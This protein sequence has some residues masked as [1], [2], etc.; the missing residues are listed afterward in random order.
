MTDAQ[1]PVE[2]PTAVG[3]VNVGL[4]LLADAVRLQGRPVVQVDW[5][6]P[7]GGDPALD[8]ETLARSLRCVLKRAPALIVIAH[9]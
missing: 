6:I 3:V 9:P 4:G 5:R 8:P 1:P 7:A 2:L